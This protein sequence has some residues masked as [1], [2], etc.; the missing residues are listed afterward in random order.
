MGTIMSAAAVIYSQT[1]DTYT[2]PSVR[3]VPTG[4]LQLLRKCQDSRSDDKRVV[5]RRCRFLARQ[6]GRRRTE[7]RS[8][9]HR[10][11][12][13]GRVDLV[14]LGWRGLAVLRG[15]GDHLH[16]AGFGVRFRDRPYCVIR[17]EVFTPRSEERRVG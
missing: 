8:L 1:A 16:V 11:E 6:R 15:E 13:H 4:R 3:P 17:E 9:A 10:L 2:V 12:R 5:V 7:R 14:L